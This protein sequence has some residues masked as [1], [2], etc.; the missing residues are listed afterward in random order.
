MLQINRISFLYIRRADTPCEKHAGIIEQAQ[1]FDQ[2]TSH[3]MR[4]GGFSKEAGLVFDAVFS[5]PGMCGETFTACQYRGNL[6]ELGGT[7]G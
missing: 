3:A 1:D 2:G 6:A 5:G 4:D 7:S